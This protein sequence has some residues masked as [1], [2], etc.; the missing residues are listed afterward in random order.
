MFLVRSK[1]IDLDFSETV[2]TQPINDQEEVSDAE[3]SG[4]K[5]SNRE[6]KRDTDAYD[7][8]DAS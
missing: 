2:E 7:E 5:I 8:M 6:P 3:D 1:D 4:A